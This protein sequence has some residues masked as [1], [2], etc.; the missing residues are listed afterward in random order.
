MVTTEVDVLY[1]Q[2]ADLQAAQV[3]LSFLMGT[4]SLQCQSS[5]ENRTCGSNY[6]RGVTFTSGTVRYYEP[7]ENASG[8]SPPAMRPLAQST[9]KAS[10]GY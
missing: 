8:I 6:A 2:N 9:S 3:V 5:S 10:S 7:D 4:S 1:N